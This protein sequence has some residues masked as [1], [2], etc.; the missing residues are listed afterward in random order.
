MSAYHPQ[1]SAHYLPSSHSPTNTLSRLKT[2]ILIRRSNLRVR[3]EESHRN[4][5]PN[6][7]RI[8]PPQ[9]RPTHPP[10]QHGPPYPAEISERVVA[11]RD[12][13]AWLAECGA[14]GGEVRGEEDVEE[15]VCELIVVSWL[16]WVGLEGIRQLMSMKAR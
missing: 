9:S 12:V 14:A 3:K 4:Q 2:H 13:L 10:S 15:G 11:P 16:G 7:H 1:I 6:N 5:S 8:L